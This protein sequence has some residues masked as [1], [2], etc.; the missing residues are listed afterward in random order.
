MSKLLEVYS[1]K[2]VKEFG[3]ALK[4]ALRDEKVQDFASLIDLEGA[5]K[6]EAFADALRRFLRRNFT[7][8]EKQGWFWPSSESLE[9]VIRL[10][11]TMGVPV[12]R[13]ALISYALTFQ[14]KTQKEEEKTQ[15]EEE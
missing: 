3:Q 1:N 7:R 9:E 12:V 13:A 15:K 10:A 8:A 5:E 6:Q 4:K 11:D 14:P 2:A